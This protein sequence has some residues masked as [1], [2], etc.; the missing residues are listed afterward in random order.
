MNTSNLCP[1]NDLR[2]FRLNADEAVA[3]RAAPW[4]DACVATFH[5]RVRLLLKRGLARQDAEDL[6]ERLHLM[7]ARAEYRW[8]CIECANL[9]GSVLKGWRCRAARVAGLL[10]SKVS[11]RF[12]TTPRN[13]LGFFEEPLRITRQRSKTS[14]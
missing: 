12:V 2:P 11:Y 8:M 13:C 3:F 6:A 14:R 1:E 7:D 10:S 4:N 9:R 5:A